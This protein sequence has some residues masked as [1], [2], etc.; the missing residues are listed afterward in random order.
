MSIAKACKAR[1]QYLMQLLIAF[2][3][4]GWAYLVILPAQVFASVDFVF[5]YHDSAECKRVYPLLSLLHRLRS[6]KRLSSIAL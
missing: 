6:C 5:L 4:E 3:D 2:L 1:T